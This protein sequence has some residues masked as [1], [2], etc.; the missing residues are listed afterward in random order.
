MI[1][2]MTSVVTVISASLRCQPLSRYDNF[3]GKFAQVSVMHSLQLVQS[4]W[5]AQAVTIHIG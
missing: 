1:A 2:S 4:V 3:A 5:D